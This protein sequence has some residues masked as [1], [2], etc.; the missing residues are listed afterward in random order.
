MPDLKSS[1][2]L[3]DKDIPLPQP[4]NLA[5]P[6]PISAYASPGVNPAVLVA[7]GYDKV[8]QDLLC[9]NPNL[10]KGSILAAAPRDD[11][12]PPALTMVLS[13][14]EGNGIPERLWTRFESI[15]GARLPVGIAA[16][17]PYA[18]IEPATGDS[19]PRP[20]R[21]AAAEHAAW[22]TLGQLTPPQSQHKDYFPHGHRRSSASEIAAWINELSGQHTIDQTVRDSAWFK[23]E[24]CCVWE[25]TGLCKY[26]SSCQVSSA[27]AKDHHS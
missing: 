18:R 19:T 26:G 2:T 15:G 4:Y 24:I 8:L 11:I 3:S 14:G 1:R 13:P 5:Y 10:L 23:T 21:F 9:T 27:F 22:A 16:A 12:L 20:P 17:T 6:H 7:S 25:D